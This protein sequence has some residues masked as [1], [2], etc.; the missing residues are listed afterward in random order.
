MNRLLFRRNF[1]ALDLLQFLD[2]AL[3]LLGLGRLGAEA[4]DE[5]LELFDALALVLI[6]GLQL[7]APLCLLLLVVVE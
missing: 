7:R 3:H 6:G 2:A 1:D 5:R 4:V